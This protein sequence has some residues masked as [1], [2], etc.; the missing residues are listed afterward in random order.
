MTGQ[1]H[2]LVGCA[3]VIFQDFTYYTLALVALDHVAVANLQLCQ[4]IRNP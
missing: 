3:P 1:V 2:S 4:G